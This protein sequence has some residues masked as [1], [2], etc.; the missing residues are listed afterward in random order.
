MTARGDVPPTGK[1]ERL[2]KNGEAG[3]RRH[4]VVSVLQ[5][6]RVSGMSANFLLSVINVVLAARSGVE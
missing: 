3:E 4:N 5:R 2:T 1:I 6:E